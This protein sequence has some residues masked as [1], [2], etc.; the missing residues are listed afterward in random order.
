MVMISLKEPKKSTEHKTQKDFVHD[1]PFQKG[2]IGEHSA[3]NS[4]F[5]EKM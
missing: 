5:E 4:S 2:A 3:A 1:E